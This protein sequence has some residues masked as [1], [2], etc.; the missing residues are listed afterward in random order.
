LAKKTI[1]EIDHRSDDA[2][3]RIDYYIHCG[4]DGVADGAGH[5]TE[6]VTDI[7]K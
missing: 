7:I 6:S 2:F 5:P 1:E 4:R 3:D